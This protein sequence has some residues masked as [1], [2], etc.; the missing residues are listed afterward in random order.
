[1]AVPRLCTFELGEYNEHLLI[2]LLSNFP[3]LLT[4]F[5]LLT[6]MRGYPN[7]RKRGLIRKKPQI[8]ARLTL[9]QLPNSQEQSD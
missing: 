8:I 9:R 7:Q 6:R 4:T 3:K 1:M 2:S 5:L